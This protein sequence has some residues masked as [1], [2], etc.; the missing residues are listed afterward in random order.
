V[1]GVLPS[2]PPWGAPWSLGVPLG[3]QPHSQA[4]TKMGHGATQ[5]ASGSVCMNGGFS[6]D[7][8]TVVNPKY[9]CSAQ[10]RK[11]VSCY[12]GLFGL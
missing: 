4:G 8:Q 5:S 2:F 11:N 3:A 10:G 9:G 6:W 12:S 7:S 1:A